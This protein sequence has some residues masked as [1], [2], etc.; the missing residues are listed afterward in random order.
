MKWIVALYFD[1]EPNCLYG[2]F[3]SEKEA[4]EWALN[5]KLRWDA[6]DIH[7]VQ[8]PEDRERAFERAI[9]RAMDMKGE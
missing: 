5:C 1:Y 8:Q 6:Y 7:E 4:R 9:G 3:N 2:P